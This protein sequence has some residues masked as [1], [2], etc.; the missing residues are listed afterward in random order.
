MEVEGQSFRAVFHE[1]SHTDPKLLDVMTSADLYVLVYA[2]D[3]LESFEL[4]PGIADLLKKVGFPPAWR[5][6]GEG[7]Q[8]WRRL[9]NLPSAFGF[10]S[11][12]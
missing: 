12:F 3:S 9:R 10:L 4:V 5:E 1:A 11:A 8:G 6:R 2:I 7:G